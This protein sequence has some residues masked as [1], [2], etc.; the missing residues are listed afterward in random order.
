MTV[1][2]KC[3]TLGNALDVRQLV[4]VVRP[5]FANLM[6]AHRVGLYDLL[7]LKTVATCVVTNADG[8][9]DLTDSFSNVLYI[10]FNLVRHGLFVVVHR[11]DVILVAVVA[12]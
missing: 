8:I 11:V 5:V 2:L 10:G 12:N 1:L 9:V 7:V 4:V 3:F 6:G